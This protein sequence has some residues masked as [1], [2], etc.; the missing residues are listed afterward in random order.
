MDYII[1]PKTLI[2]DKHN[3]KKALNEFVLEY[4]ELFKDDNFEYNSIKAESILI[5]VGKSKDE[6]NNNL[7]ED[8]KNIGKA[9]KTVGKDCIIQHCFTPYGEGYFAIWNNDKRMFVHS[10]YELTGVGAAW[11]VLTWI[12][13]FTAQALLTHYLSELAKK[14]KKKYKN[15]TIESNPVHIKQAYMGFIM[16]NFVYEEFPEMIY[17][18]DFLQDLQ[19]EY[20]SKYKSQY[21]SYI[22]EVRE[23]KEKDMCEWYNGNE[24]TIYYFVEKSLHEAIYKIYSNREELESTLLWA[25]ARKVISGV[26]NLIKQLL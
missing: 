8:I 16:N 14:L 6:F 3:I 11:S 7:K 18:T 17:N 21:A 1:N 9:I 23:T 4:G 22:K 19:K 24:N 2:F 5:R 20:I 25:K 15:I 10:S 12:Y 13:M 26:D